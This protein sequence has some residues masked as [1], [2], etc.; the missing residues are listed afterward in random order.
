[1]MCVLSTCSDNVPRATPIEY[2][3][4]GFDLYLAGDPGTKID[5]IRSNPRVSVGIFDPKFAETRN[6]LD[7]E[8]LQIT[9]QAH[10]IERGEPEFLEA[11]RIFELPETGFEGWGGTFIRIEPDTI[12]LLNIALKQQDFAGRQIWRPLESQP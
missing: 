6:W 3:S 4:K 8:G 7:V 9:G 10:L 2:R 11:S 5:N 12:E 1:M